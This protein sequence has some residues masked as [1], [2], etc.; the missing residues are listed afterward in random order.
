MKYCVT[1]NKKRYEIEVER[2]NAA[3]MSTT[4]IAQ[5]VKDSKKEANIQVDI[6]AANPKII[7]PEQKT[8][9]VSPWLEREVVKAPMAGGIIDV[10]V[11]VGTAVK[12]G[13]IL[14]LLEAMKMENEITAH[15]DGIVADIKVVKGSHVSAD[16]I[17]MVIK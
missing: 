6:A 12:I 4:E 11:S 5:G 9:E 14:I 17:L 2:G 8:I 15:I 10:K 7:E 1:I 16:D 13:D 3:I